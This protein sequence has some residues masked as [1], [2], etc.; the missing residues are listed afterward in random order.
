MLSSLRARLTLTSVLFIGVVLLIFLYIGWKQLRVQRQRDIDPILTPIIYDACMRISS[1]DDWRELK[2]KLEKSFPDIFKSDKPMHIMLVDH[3]NKTSI[4]LNSTE[5]LDKLSLVE[6]L[7]SRDLLRKFDKQYAARD[8][9]HVNSAHQPLIFLPP[10]ETVELAGVPHRVIS[11]SSPLYTLIVAASIDHVNAP[12]QRT[13]NIMLVAAPV[14]AIIMG[15]LCWFLVGR[16]MRP[17]K[18]INATARYIIEGRLSER[19]D[20]S[21]QESQEI[22]ETVVILNDMFERMERNFLQASRFSSDASHELKSPIAALQGTLEIALRHTD[23]PD[24]MIEAL[25]TAYEEVQKL[26]QIINSL[27]TLTRIDS[28]SIEANIKKT[29]ISALVSELCEDS[30]LIAE[31]CD[32]RFSAFIT[33]EIYID[34]DPTLLRQVL[35]N[36]LS[37]AIKYNHPE[38]TV[39]CTLHRYHEDYVIDVENT[40]PHIPEEN[41]ENIFKRFVRLDRARSQKHVKGFGLGLNIASELARINRCSLKLVYSENKKNL[42]R[43]TLPQKHFTSA[44]DQ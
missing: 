28:G 39:T 16:A 19:I 21:T 40:G 18:N 27:L 6:H 44:L 30:Q 41:K 14:I 34:L 2:P 20:Q 29:C 35:S 36:L 15:G 8:H 4:D 38:G 1:V 31:D 23:N 25:G 42:F 13:L 10:I 12:I 43:I 22:K 32:I 37:N 11:C 24:S 9:Y 26:K 3:R 33:P 17:L 7:P 5:L